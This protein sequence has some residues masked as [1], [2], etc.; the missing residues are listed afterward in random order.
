M[1]TS[2]MKRI[3]SVIGV[4]F[5]G[6][7]NVRVPLVLSWVQK[8]RARGRTRTVAI[9]RLWLERRY[10]FYVGAKAVIHESV[11][12]PHPVG[13]VIGDGVEV[14]EDCTIYQGVTLGGA[15]TGD[16]QSRRYP[17][18]DKGSTI[19]AGA[20]II[21]AIKLGEGSIVGANAVVTKDVPAYHVAVGV[22][23][24]CHAIKGKRL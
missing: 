19:F 11:R 21:G 7:G 20:K 6:S 10:G 1:I 3:I 8:S 12:F 13:I 16:A 23:A 17:I 18:V 14:H 15:R 2:K 9:L 4:I 24:K 22:P 5:L